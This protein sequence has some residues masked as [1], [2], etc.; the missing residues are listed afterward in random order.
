VGKFSHVL[1]V[2]A[3]PRLPTDGNTTSTWSKIQV[4][5]NNVARSITGVQLLDRV[6][7]PDL[8]DLAVIRA[9]TSWW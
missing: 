8:L 1:A 9:S 7:I 2:V 6:N 3:T 5:F 4:A